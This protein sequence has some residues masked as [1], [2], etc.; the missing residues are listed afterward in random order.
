[1]IRRLFFLATLLF[2]AM[3]AEGINTPSASQTF[4]DGQVIDADDIN[5]IE[6][7]WIAWVNNE[8]LN[9]GN[10][11]TVANADS[12]IVNGRLVAD[13]ARVTGIFYIQSDFRP[14]DNG[15]YSF[16][17]PENYLDTIYVQNI[18]AYHTVTDSLS[19]TDSLTVLAPARINGITALPSTTTITNAFTVTGNSTF[20]GT[21]I[22]N[23]GTVTTANIDGGTIDGATIGGSSAGAITAT[24]LNATGGG[25]LTGT[26][27]DLGS[28]TT[29]DINGGTINGITDLAVV[30]GGT[31][32]SDASSART[33]LGVAIGTDVQAYSATADKDSANVAVTSGTIYGIDSLSVT[34]GIEVAR[35]KADSINIGSGDFIVSS[36]NNFSKIGA[37]MRANFLLYDAVVDSAG[38]GDYTTI[39]SAL[40]SGARVIFVKKGT[41]PDSTWIGYSGVKIVGSGISTLITNANNTSGASMTINAE[42]VEVSNCAFRVDGGG[43]GGNQITFHVR[44]GGTRA[45]IHDCWFIDS[46]VDAVQLQ[47]NDIIFSNNYVLDADRYAIYADGIGVKIHGNILS[48]ADASYTVQVAGRYVSIVGNTFKSSGVLNI[49]VSA[50]SCIVIGNQWHGAPVDGGQTGST[51]TNN[52]IITAY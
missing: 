19:V 20:A 25:S 46:D 29:V 22:A 16:G 15:V 1:M 43:V 3:P 51:I 26:W 13:T 11:L 47:A 36:V 8:L 42:D 40:A 5:G 27:T 18:D 34:N 45:N 14:S 6:T 35:V 12:F 4:F 23:L 41:Y 10:N 44:S 7:T 33:N 38:Y 31:G 17:M 39:R 9:N 32:A 2:M 24:T 28:V 49:T 48:G 30:D 52:P 50:D 37:G 21:T